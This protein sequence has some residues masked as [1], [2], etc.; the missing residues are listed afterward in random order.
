MMIGGGALCTL[1]MAIIALDMAWPVQFAAVSLL[2]VGFYTLHSC[3]QVEASELSTTSRGAAMS[4]HSLFFF[5][6]HASGPVL[7][8]MGFRTIGPASTVL[9]AAP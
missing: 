1:T 5:L 8:G 6:G 9:L 7:Y 2:G 4:L 3:I